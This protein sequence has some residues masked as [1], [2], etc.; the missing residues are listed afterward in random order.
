MSKLTIAPT[1]K[2]QEQM[3]ESGVT[4][5]VVILCLLLAFFFGYVIPII[6]VKL[7]NTYLGSSHLPPGAV[8]VLGLP[9]DAA[10]EPGIARLDA[11]WWP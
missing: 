2:R 7:S 6:D 4:L 1:E 10:I 8:A 9:V 5:R 3:G 11:F